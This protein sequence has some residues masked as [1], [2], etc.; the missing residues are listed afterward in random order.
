MRTRSIGREG[1]TLVELM[2]SMFLTV[3][4]GAALIRLTMGQVRF[5]DQQ[6][7]VRE[8]RGVSRS[9]VNRLISDLR[10]VETQ[11]GLQAAVAGGQDFTIRV[12]YAWG[13]LCA[14][15]A[16]VSTIS[17]LPVDPTMYAEGGISGF[18]WRNAN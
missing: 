16:G 14:H 12:P 7:A 3:I 17:L 13:L 2:I 4:V 1:F 10:A 11:K 8:A 9:G 18:A 6:E 5:M 15:V